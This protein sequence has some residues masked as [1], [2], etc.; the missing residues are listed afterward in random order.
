[1]T[2]GLSAQPYHEEEKKWLPTVVTLNGWSTCLDLL[3]LRKLTVSLSDT[4]SRRVELQTN[5]Q[6]PRHF[7]DRNVLITISPI[8]CPGWMVHHSMIDLTAQPN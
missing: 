2:Y 6:H 8:I 1:M 3:V 7:A 4:L 5:P